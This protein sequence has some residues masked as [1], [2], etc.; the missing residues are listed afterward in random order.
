ME[1][2]KRVDLAF[3]ADRVWAIMSD[4]Y[5]RGFELD[6]GLTDGIEVIEDEQG[7]PMRLIHFNA[8]TGGGAMTEWLE[9]IDHAGMRFT[10]SVPDPGPLPFTNY[11]G[12]VRVEPIE[13][14]RSQLIW[15]CA[16]DVVPGDEAKMQAFADLGMGEVFSSLE[17]MLEAESAG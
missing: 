16:C 9:T 17:R 11:R 2:E 12:R 15:G 8:E 7:R 13:G 4:F 5:G 14:G 3:S 6:K 1:L 10:Y